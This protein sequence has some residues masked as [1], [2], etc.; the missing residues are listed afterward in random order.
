MLFF[1]T[2]IN[3]KLAVNDY[4]AIANQLASYVANCCIQSRQM[5]YINSIVI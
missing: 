4:I 5:Y 1:V 3:S 2:N